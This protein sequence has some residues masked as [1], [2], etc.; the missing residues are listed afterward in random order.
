MRRPRK[1][2]HIA[3]GIKSARYQKTFA[4][5]INTYD[6]YLGPPLLVEKRT[7]DRLFENGDLTLVKLSAR[8]KQRLTELGLD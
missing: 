5:N 2:R 6:Y 3:I 1:V 7:L 4:M 8:F